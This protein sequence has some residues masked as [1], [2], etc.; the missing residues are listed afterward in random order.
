MVYFHGILSYT[1]DKQLS[2]M[3]SSVV[4]ENFSIYLPRLCYA[5]PATS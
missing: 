4:K 3:N 1:T 5:K 2:D